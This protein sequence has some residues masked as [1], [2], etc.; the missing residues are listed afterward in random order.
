MGEDL[1]K[2]WSQADLI[3]SLR[4]RLEASEHD[5]QVILGL[6]IERDRL[7]AEVERLKALMN[8]PGIGDPLAGLLVYRRLAWA[9]MDKVTALESQLSTIRSETRRATLEEAANALI[10][11]SCTCAQRIRALSS[12]GEPLAQCWRQDLGEQCACHPVSPVK[13]PLTSEVCPSC[14]RS[15]PDFKEHA[16]TCR[17]PVKPEEGKRGCR[18]VGEH[19]EHCPGDWPRATPPPPEG[20][21]EKGAS[22]Q[23]CRKHLGYMYGNVCSECERLARQTQEKP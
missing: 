8:V 19:A 10:L 12:P 9:E 5:D 1:F 7:R 13:Q 2:V 18:C 14:C 22:L 17:S 4:K 21:G 23:G 6:Q 20:K 11:M 15:L 3:A 16:E